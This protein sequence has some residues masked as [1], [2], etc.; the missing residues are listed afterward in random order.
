MTHNEREPEHNP[1]TAAEPEMALVGCLLLDGDECDSVAQIVNRDDFHDSRCRLFFAA[2]LK[3]RD[4]GKATDA[5]S[6][7]EQLRADGKLEEAGD[8]QAADQLMACVPHQYHAEHYARLVR[9][10]ADRRAIQY[11]AR[12]AGLMAADLS[13]TPGEI[14]GAVD[15]RLHAI[16]ERELAGQSTDIGSIFLDVF[17]SIMDGHRG[18]ALTGFYD[19]DDK[20]TGLQPGNLIVLAARPGMGKTAFAANVGMN[21]ARRQEPVLFFSL[22]QSKLELAERLLSSEACIDGNKIRGGE[23]DEHDRDKCMQAASRLGEL[24]FH[25]DATATQTVSQIAARA[26]LTKRRH[27]LALVIVDYLQLITPDNRRDPREQQVATI[28]RTLK[29]MAKD[30]EVP[31]IVLAQ[32]NRECEKRPDKRPVLSDLR[33]SGSLEQDADHVWMLYRPHYYGLV[34]PQGGDYYGPSEAFVL[35]QKNRGGETGQ[36]PLHWDATTTTFHNAA[37]EP[38]GEAY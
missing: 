4:A 2:I 18:G 21:F 29:I 17:D 8:Y 9:D 13:K 15:T 27:G 20:I 32:L 25:I 11:A 36:A 31:V 19:L 24:P 38:I 7:C 30:L 33:E 5:L 10:R 12:D 28:S 37:F 23:L 34:R 1:I 14:V 3:L 35:I 22:E 16:L 6:V 26:R